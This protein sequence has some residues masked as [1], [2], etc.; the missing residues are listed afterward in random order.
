MKIP[1][2]PLGQINACYE[3]ALSQ[4]I[5]AA[6]DSGWYIL[7]KELRAFETSFADF[8]GVPFC[9]GCGNGLDA[10]TLIFR[11]YLELGILKEGDEVIVPAN[12]YIATVLAITQ[13]RLTPVLVEPAVSTFNLD[14]RLLSAACS[15]KTRAILPVHLYGRAAVTE[16]LLDFASRRRLLVIED[17]AQAHGAVW[18]G[19]R[20]GC[21]GGAA[22][23][24]FYPGKNLGCLGDGGAVTTRNEELAQV[25]RALGNYG[26]HEKYVNDYQGVNSRLDEIQAATLS[27][28]LP[29]L[30]ADNEIRRQIA[31]RYTR[32]I[33]NEN[34]ILP[35]F[36]AAARSHVWHLYVIRSNRREKLRTYLKEKGI[37]TLIHY[38]IPPHL[39]KAYAGKITHSGLPITENMAQEVLSIPIHPVLTGDQVSYVIEVLN[40]FRP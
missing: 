28:K 35:E 16:E 40:A 7:G 2:L 1:F 18:D 38:P 29:G 33:Q 14:S 12:T 8:C 36:P 37:E 13:N 23:F 15:S 4:R 31:L 19:K 24:S 11:A 39:Q 32:E 21:L 22:A 3:P 20:A 9:I 6:V 17:A 5:T 10:L 30:D 34:L 27:V 25:I 26:S